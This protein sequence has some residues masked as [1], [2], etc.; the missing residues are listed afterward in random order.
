MKKTDIEKENVD[1]NGKIIMNV[2]FTG[3]FDSTYRMLELSF[4]DVIIQPYY[5]YNKNRKSRNIEV[6]TIVSLLK[7]LR[8]R[9]TTKAE[10]KDV[11]I[12]DLDEYMPISEDIIAGYNKVREQSVFGGQYP[13]LN[14]V[15]KTL[16]GIQIS[17]ETL[18][19]VNSETRLI[20]TLHQRDRLKYY[21]NNPALCISQLTGKDIPNEYYVMFSNLYFPENILHMSKRDMLKKFKEWDALDIA[22]AT[23]VCHYPVKGQACGWCLPCV[24]AVDK[25]GMWR[26]QGASRRRY[27]L[28]KFYLFKYNIKKFFDIKLKKLRK[29]N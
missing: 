27:K 14:Q 21:E 13:W 17:T 18:D 10:I 22:E 1:K 2:M 16:K 4:E 15:G 20:Y 29:N 9:E 12:S 19:E 3:G 5:I 8:E 11:L 25:T 26:V 7:M 24:S 23:W 6:E 28:R